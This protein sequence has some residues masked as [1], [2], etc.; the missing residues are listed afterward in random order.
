MN[1]GMPPLRINSVYFD[2]MPL[3]AWLLEY[4]EDQLLRCVIGLVTHPFR[5]KDFRARVRTIAR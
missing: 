3:I 5:D 1:G 2:D 4:P